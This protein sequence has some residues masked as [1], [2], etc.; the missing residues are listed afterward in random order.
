MTYEQAKEIENKIRLILFG[1]IAPTYQSIIM[2]VFVVPNMW[3]LAKAVYRERLNYAG[4]P[5]LP[6]DNCTLVASFTDNSLEAVKDVVMQDY[7][8]LPKG[9]EILELVRNLPDMLDPTQE[10]AREQRKSR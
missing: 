4:F 10:R 8:S 3:V 6:E 1:Q 2:D 5:F 7:K 9:D